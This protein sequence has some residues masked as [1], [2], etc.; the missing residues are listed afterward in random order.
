M[1]VILVVVFNF[2]HC[3]F[4]L[5]I[6]ILIYYMS[7]IYRKGRDGYFYYQAYIKNPNTGKKDKRVYRSLGTKDKETA[8]K[9]KVELDRK[10]A[11]KEIVKKK[12]ISPYALKFIFLSF[13]FFLVLYILIPAKSDVI[14]FDSNT[15][16]NKS[17]VPYVEQD[18]LEKTT[19][20]SQIKQTT[21]D[22]QNFDNKKKQ[23]DQNISKVMIEVIT[24]YT[25][26]RVEKL[27]S[28]FSQ[29]YLHVTIDRKYDQESLKLLCK[30]LMNQH[31]DFSNIIIC[32]Y[33]KNSIGKE[34]ALNPNHN[35]TFTEQKDNWIGMYSYNDVE[36][37]YFDAE[38]T[39]YLNK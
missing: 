2:N 20:L 23:T 25:I 30:N 8:E 6:Q 18:S 36:G 13:L 19:G 22:T 10:F 28:V 35:F 39:S 26:Q 15:N 14:F 29:G 16:Y 7:S 31:K 27:P 5:L 1:V 3:N 33:L 12:I 34:M 11:K 4:Q 37:E 9:I 21:N 38:P 32:L 17:A 24:D